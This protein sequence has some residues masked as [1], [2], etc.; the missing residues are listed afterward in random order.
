MRVRSDPIK[1]SL[2]LSR[3]LRLSW[4][5]RPARDEQRVRPA[6]ARGRAL[7]TRAAGRCLATCCLK[8][9]PPR[10]HLPKGAHGRLSFYGFSCDNHNEHNNAMHAPVNLRLN[11]KEESDSLTENI[12]NGKKQE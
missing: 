1:A 6:P 3:L 5:G 2:S 4:R 9:R 7:G 8:R 11:P 10:L 12:M